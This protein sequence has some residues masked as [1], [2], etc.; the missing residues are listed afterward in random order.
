MITHCYKNYYVV[1][2]NLY[3]KI[4][5]LKDHHCKGLSEPLDYPNYV[6]NWFEQFQLPDLVFLMK[7]VRYVV[8]FITPK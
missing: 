6:V 4:Y 2:I 3:F 1:C 5:L 7:S 8:F